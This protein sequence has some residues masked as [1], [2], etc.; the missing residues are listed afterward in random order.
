VSCPDWP[1]LVA[2]RE[3]RGEDPPEWRAS[4]DHLAGCA[5]C[6]HRALA[7]DPLLV[8]Q[9]LPAVAVA[10]GEVAGVLQAVATLRRSRRWGAV[11]PAPAGDPARR[12]PLAGGR[13]RWPAAAAALLAAALTLAPAG[14][15]TGRGNGDRGVLSAPRLTTARG[16]ADP[17][18]TSAFVEDL[19]LPD[20]RVYQL[21]EEELSVVMIVDPSFDL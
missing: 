20:A 4:L 3:V 2:Y 19:D 1:S 13:W 7:A 14:P 17:I 16:Q 15:G 18:L 10:P 8:F 21:A 11:S 12:R 6:R 5:D 9:R